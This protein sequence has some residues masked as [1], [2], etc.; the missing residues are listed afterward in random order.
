MKELRAW[1]WLKLGGLRAR[2]AKPDWPPST[3]MRMWLVT[4]SLV[5]LT[6]CE[7]DHPMERIKE[8]CQR[9]LARKANARSITA[10]AGLSRRR[11][12][13]NAAELNLWTT[14]NGARIAA[15]W[16]SH[17]VR[18]ADAPGRQR[19]RKIKRKKL[20]QARKKRNITMLPPLFTGAG[21]KRK[22]PSFGNSSILMQWRSDDSTGTV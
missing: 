22:A 3:Q 4:L 13:D 16:E 11:Y 20:T 14:R 2:Q 5:L 18:A 1:Y 15:P 17:P 12:R 19:G 8:S 10:C 21:R 7:R 6:A 9:N